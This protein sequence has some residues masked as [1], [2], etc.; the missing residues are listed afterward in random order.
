MKNL[1]VELL[2]GLYGFPYIAH[3]GKSLSLKYKAKKTWMF[4]DVSIFDQCCY[5]YDYIPTL[6][7]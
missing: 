6:N 2:F 3:A 1:I 4:S 7:L 5:L